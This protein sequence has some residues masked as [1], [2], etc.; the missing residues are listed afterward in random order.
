MVVFFISPPSPLPPPRSKI[1][2]FTWNKKLRSA[3]NPYWKGRIGTVG[4]LLLTSLDQLIFHLKIFFTFVTKHVILGQLYWT[5]PF[6]LCSLPGSHTSISSWLMNGC[7]KLVCLSR[8]SLLQMNV[9]N[10]S[11]LLGPFASFEENEAA[12]LCVPLRDTV[13]K[14]YYQDFYT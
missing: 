8:E 12:Q 6:N 1:P 10:H 4:L 7:N 3:G 9:V 14:L 2:P 5:F 13:I 11:S